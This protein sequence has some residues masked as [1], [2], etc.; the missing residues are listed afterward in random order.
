MSQ[1]NKT[2]TPR[3]DAKSLNNLLFTV[4]TDFARQLETENAELKRQVEELKA[5]PLNV[6]HTAACVVE[7]QNCEKERDS[8]KSQLAKICDGTGACPDG[9]CVACKLV[10]A[11]LDIEHL[12][13]QLEEAGKVERSLTDR[14]KALENQLVN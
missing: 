13:A 10:N 14:I 5:T 9:K 3:T 4:D 11:Q 1:N 12:K 6:L 2:E 8:L 7:W